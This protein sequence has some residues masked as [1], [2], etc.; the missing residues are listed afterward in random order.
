VKLCPPFFNY[1]QWI[2]VTL[3]AVLFCVADMGQM[4]SLRLNAAITIAR[5]GQVCQYL[6]GRYGSAGT[7]ISL[8]VKGLRERIYI[9]GSIFK[10]NVN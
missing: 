9:G 10:S 5:R 3:S 7:L 8:F 2:V 4:A 1:A 6:L